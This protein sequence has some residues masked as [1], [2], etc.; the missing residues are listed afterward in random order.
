MTEGDGIQE[1]LAGT[2]ADWEHEEDDSNTCCV[3]GKE[4]SNEPDH[5]NDIYCSTAC[6]TKDTGIKIECEDCGY[7]DCRCCW[8]DFFDRDPEP[9]EARFPVG[10]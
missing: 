3:C 2:I 1:N 10:V 4:T 9:Q 8:E 7:Q 5:Y 6:Y